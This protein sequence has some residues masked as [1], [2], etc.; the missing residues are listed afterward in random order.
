MLAKL[1]KFS[2]LPS[3]LCIKSSLRTDLGSIANDVVK[4]HRARILCLPS[5]RNGVGFAS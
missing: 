2:E 1:D 5:R 3:V 4:K